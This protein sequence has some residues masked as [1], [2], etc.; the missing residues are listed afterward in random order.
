MTT[1]LDRLERKIDQL[2]ALAT[3]NLIGDQIMSQEMDQLV[4]AVEVNTTVDQSVLTF[5]QGVAQQITDAA[6]DRT[7]SLALAATVRASTDAVSAALL[8]NTPVATP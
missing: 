4:A 5:L 7:K 1:Q 8:A 2:I 3:A 6:G